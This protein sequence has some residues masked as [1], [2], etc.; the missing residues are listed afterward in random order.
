MTAV[1]PYGSWKSPITLDLLVEKAVGLAN[2]LATPTAVYWVE[3][4]PSEAG[5]QVVVRLP[6]DGSSGPEDVFGE[7]FSARTLVHEYGGRSY[8]VR[9]ETVYF[10]NFAD[11]RLYRVEAG[12]R[13]VAVTPEPAAERAVRYAAPVATP[14]GRHLFCIR[15]RHFE[16]DL[17]SSVLNDVVVLATDGSSEP[18][19][20]AE[21]HDFFSHVTLSPD[22]RRLSW[23]SWDHPAMPWDETELWE[24][25]LGADLLPGRVRRVAGGGGES[26]VQP[27]YSPAGELFFVSD[28]TGW[29]NLY[30]ASEDGG[31]P[32]S[33]IEAE[34]G[35]P[36]WVIGNS[37]YALL[38]GGDVLAFIS[39][40]G[41][42]RLGRLEGG[43][44]S[45][46]D[47][48]SPYSEFAALQ[49]SPDGAFVVAV[50]GSASRPPAVVRIDTG[51]AG[52]GAVTALRSSR[53]VPVEPAY[54]SMP[55]AIE[56]PTE[57]GLSAFALYYPPRNPDFEAP[58]GELPPLIVRS[59]GGPTS[60]SNSV[61]NL[62]IQFWTSR[63]F[64]VVDV[65]YGGSTGYGRPYRE[66]LRQRWGVVDLDDCANAATYLAESGR[67]D[68][69]RLLIHGGSA[70]G[71]TTLCALTFRDV[72]A[73][74]ASYF[75]VA[76]AGALARE[77]HKFESRYLDS[78]IGPWP[79]AKDTY[80]ERSPIFHTDLLRTPMILFQ[81]LEDKV[82]PPSQ[83][84]AMV[85][86][87]DEKQIPHAYV[88]YEGE[89]HGFRKA[90]NVKRTS[91]AELY[92]YGR[93]L[94]F[95]PADHLEP[96]EIAHGDGLAQGS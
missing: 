24:A 34:I 74:G 44:G 51:T 54:L 17:S 26:V 53:E 89:Q 31:T 19:V 86:A 73:A 5:R 94:G 41:L 11:Q 71:Y 27:K 80:E 70:G 92:F 18:S 83:A 30:K 23:V 4:R 47:V 81:G 29:W 75:G 6:L 1:R 78:M 9:E 21:G 90:E 45:F 28:R 59:H 14:D 77:T 60:Q 68:R 22:G 20:V 42:G 2:P 62:G 15:E 3:A 49:A 93:V 33:P 48:E 32:L 87:L 25:E 56:F 69:E 57:D 72:F 96:V 85:R 50:A 58:A 36:D 52:G 66:R 61:L 40:K 88:A 63:G 55:E 13:P 7:G 38:P 65:N 8:T 67:A 95:E 64:A 12:G 82:V 37:S 43:A 84:E 16:P 35:G 76:D 91:E 10:A 79:E 39:D 46:H